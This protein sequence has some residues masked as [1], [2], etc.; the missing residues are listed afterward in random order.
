MSRSNQDKKGCGCLALVGALA[1]LA[2]GGSYLYSRNFLGQELTPNSA[3]KII[4]QEALMTGFIVTDAQD[5]SKLAEFGTP[6]AQKIVS[7]KLQKIEREITGDNPE[8]NYQKDIQPWLGGI[9]LAILPSPQGRVDY[10]LV[11][12]VGIRDK[13]KAWDF[14]RKLKKQP[15]IEVN[16]SKYK[17]FILYEYRQQQNPPVWTTMFKNYLV[18]SP[19]KIAIE[20]VID[21][22]KGEPSLAEQNRFTGV[23][24]EQLN[25]Q[26]PLMQIYLPDYSH[27]MQTALKKAITGREIPPKTRQDL[28]GISSVLMA[29][30]I[31]GEGIHA[32]AIAELTEP[33]EPKELKPVSAKLITNMPE[34]T[35][36]M[37]NG[38]R[39]NR[40]WSEIERHRDVIPELNKIISQG[41]NLVN[42]WLNL[43][44][45]RDIL[46]WLDGE[47][48]LGIFTRENNSLAP[49]GLGGLVLVETSDRP[50]AETTIG[51]LEKFSNKLPFVHIEEQTI[52]GVSVTKWKT[53]QAS[54]LSYGWLNNNHLMMTIG[55]NF[56]VENTGGNLLNNKT[57]TVTTKSLPKKN[58]GRVY[59]D[60]EKSLSL[61]SNKLNNERPN[62][63]SEEAGAILNSLKGIALT[64]SKTNSNTSQIDLFLSLKNISP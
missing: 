48:A 8:I 38:Q 21:T 19:D 59:F 49:T 53:F 41:Q 52:Q 11:T 45:E 23:L 14:R 1:L 33:V 57:F 58:F 64:T 26:N 3:A 7:Q 60:V 2:F 46:A 20:R 54:L 47:F 37:V 36:L 50:R 63:L 32:Q 5:W 28:Q 24:S 16:K 25:L 34:N 29:M 13:F 17:D 12:I 40:A 35:I 56:S 15:D 9:M 55:T 31:K 30:E 6:E 18:V 22:F 39:I 44:L 51:K 27:V 10:D 61:A 42:Q 62:Y 4:P 43:D